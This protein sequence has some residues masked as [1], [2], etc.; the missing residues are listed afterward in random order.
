MLRDLGRAWNS[1]DVNRQL[2]QVQFAP[3]SRTEFKRI[4][5]ALAEVRGVQ[6]GRDGVRLR[7]LV[8]EVAEAEIDWTFD[9][10][11]LAD[12]IEELEVEGMS[13]EITEMTGNRLMVRVVPGE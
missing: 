2:C 4:A 10:N 9:L 1:R 5:G 8:N 3:C 12:V 13:F 11:R 6:G 7:E